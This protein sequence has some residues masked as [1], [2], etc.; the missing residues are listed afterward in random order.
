MKPIW[1]FGLAALLV[2]LASVPSPALSQQHFII[3]TGAEPDSSDITAGF[4][5]PI[6]Y[7]ILRNIDEAL[8]DYND[9]GTIRQTVAT[10]DYSADKKTFVFHLQHGVKFYS[11]EEFTADDVVFGFQRL[12]AKTRPFARHGK[13]VAGI[14]AVDRYTV[15]IDFKRTGCR[16][17]RRH[18]PV[19]RFKSLL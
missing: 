13:H 19:S 3:A 6:N 12:M 16:F 5:L 2:A 18:Q 9:D 8:W 15:R 14:T 10:W 4:F 11:G 17:F 1:A 7:V